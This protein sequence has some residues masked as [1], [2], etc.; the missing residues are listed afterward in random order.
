M[1]ACLQEMA[2]MNNGMRG[3]AATDASAEGLLTVLRDI[4]AA[5]FE[6]TL[7]AALASM[8]DD[9]EAKIGFVTAYE[10]AASRAIKGFSAVQIAET[11][12]EHAA[13]KAA[14]EKIVSQLVERLTTIGD[15]LGKGENTSL[16]TLK[17]LTEFTSGALRGA[18]S[19]CVGELGE[20]A[21]K[22][23]ETSRNSSKEARAVIDSAVDEIDQISLNVRLISLN[24]SVEAARAGEAGR[25]FGVIASEI[26][27]LATRSQVAVESV[28]RQLAS[29]G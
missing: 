14:A 8:I 25:G 27:N 9:D 6:A 26:Q 5:G 20:A 29:I 17:T 3:E 13:T 24:A 22:E 16:D 12:P 23:K 15:S 1:R 7:Q 19:Q 10:D 11:A 2:G 4:E 18:I 21:T 28:R